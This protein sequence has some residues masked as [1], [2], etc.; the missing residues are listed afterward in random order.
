M[1][2]LD[3]LLLGDDSAAI[4]RKCFVV[5]ASTMESEERRAAFCLA[6]IDCELPDSDGVSNP[7][8]C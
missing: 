5:A 8:E 1:A 2:A 6:D 3:A 4:L 7:K